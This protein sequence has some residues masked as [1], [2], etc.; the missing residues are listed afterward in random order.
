MTTENTTQTQT[1]ETTTPCR[2]QYLAALAARDAIADEESAEYQA[3]NETLTV[4]RDEYRYSDE[5]RTW[6]FGGEGGE[7]HRDTFESRPC[8][9]DIAEDGDWDAAIEANSGGSIA[10]TVTAECEETG[11]RLYRLCV[12]D[13]EEPGCLDGCEHDW[14]DGQVRGHGAGITSTDHCALCGL[15]RTAYTCSQGSNA[16]TEH[17]HD[18][19]RY[20]DGDWGQAEIEE[21][22][23]E[24]VPSAICKAAQREWEADGDA[25]CSYVARC[26]GPDGD[27]PGTV[28]VE[29]ESATVKSEDGDRE[30]TI[31][32]W[33]DT[34][35]GGRLDSGPARWTRERAEEDAR[36]HADDS[37][38]TPC[39]DE[40][41]AAIIETGTFAADADDVRRVCA[42]AVSHTEGY[43]MLAVGQGLPDPAGIAW[44]TSGYLQVPYVTLQCGQDSVELAAAEL[45]LAC[46]E[47]D[48]SAD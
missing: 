7:G 24:D 21:H 44:A 30:V 8:L 16:A 42:A 22:H 29:I 12:I 31:Y 14:V 43:L 38:E 4:A 6:S 28:A 23:G 39:L 27:Q 3:A 47:Q 17:D 33:R 15:S 45:L 5:P 26:Y 36:G 9:Q 41:I 20:H 1:T 18:G 11:E 46:R 10:V 25:V 35:D 37:D 13:P 2:D 48:R 19:V 32:R 40:T 34:D